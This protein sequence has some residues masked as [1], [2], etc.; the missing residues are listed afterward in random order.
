MRVRL[1]FELLVALRFLR[2]GRTQS[3]LI[4]G[5]VTAGVAVTIFLTHLIG[6]LQSSIIERVLG[7]QPHVVIRPPDEVNR[8]ALPDGP[9]TLATDQPRAQRLRPVDQWESVAK[10]AAATPDVVAVSPLVTGPAFALR[11]EASKSVA[12]MGVEPDAY[13]RIV[14]MDKYL[15][16]GRFAPSGTN[17]VIGIEL[18]KDLGVSL[19][20]R[21]RVQTAG[22]REEVLTITGLFD[23]G[24]RDLNR[25][26]VFVSLRLGQSLLE[27]AGGVSQVD[28]RVTDIFEAEAIARP[29]ADAT[30]L[31][32]ESWMTT[33][34]QLLAGLKNQS[35]SLNLIRSFVTLIVALGIASVLVVSVV[36]KQR[37]IG[38]L[39]A[40]GAGR[41]QL[42]AVFLIQGALVGSVG[43]ALGASLGWGLLQIF[44]SVFRNGDGTPIFSPELPAD[45]VIGAC[46]IA[47]VVGTLAAMIPARR[48]AS[49]DPVDAIR[50]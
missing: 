35:T 39:R 10:L 20:D 47:T 24:N 11:G 33:N 31:K 50:S 45:I 12:L 16:A 4:L 23:I 25:R 2:E 40:M 19:G 21:I 6:E 3:L 30:G 44:A 28:L 41:R 36:Q 32:V 13:R 22:G 14:L 1:P 5:G 29:L 37:E 48:A 9:G 7:S 26:W 49:L 42:L 34:A 38:I 27:L 17:T 15:T 18:A 8:R 43:S 46:L